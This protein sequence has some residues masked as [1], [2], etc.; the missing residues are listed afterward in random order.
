MGRRWGKTVL[1]SALSL[2]TASQGG[3]V[4]WVVPSYRNG[5]PLWRAAETAVG[6][7][8]RDGLVDVNRSERTI[9]FSNGGGLGIYSADSPDS[10]RGEAFHLVVEDEAARIPPD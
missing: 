8:K 1:G 6:N 2:A 5:R 4:A 9:E 7:L 10:M 3:R